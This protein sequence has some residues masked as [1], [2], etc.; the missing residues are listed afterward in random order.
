MNILL[1]F[2]IYNKLDIQAIW[3]EVK[4]MRKLLIKIGK[5]D[6]TNAIIKS[7]DSNI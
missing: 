4:S 6:F 5:T 1:Y 2:F 7:H 3:S